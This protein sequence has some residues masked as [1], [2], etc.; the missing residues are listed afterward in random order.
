MLKLENVCESPSGRAGVAT[1]PSATQL[2]P[3][4]QEWLLELAVGQRTVQ[5]G[6][7]ML[8]GPEVSAPVPCLCTLNTNSGR[9]ERKGA[10][11]AGKL[12]YQPP[13]GEH[14]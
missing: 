4:G 8:G 2:C 7:D 14:D 1:L 13:G 3:L 12:N 5:E 10:A 6:R 9:Q 11:E